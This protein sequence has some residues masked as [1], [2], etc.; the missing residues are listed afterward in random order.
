MQAIEIQK[1]VKTITNSKGVPVEVILPYKIY[2]ELLELQ[3]GIDIYQQ[4]NTRESIRRA[5]ED[6]KQRK[7]K[8]FKDID[9]AIEW[10][11]S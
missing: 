6:I 2:K 7:I 8:N 4:K 5:K 11:D 9:N 10:L 1:K 3:N